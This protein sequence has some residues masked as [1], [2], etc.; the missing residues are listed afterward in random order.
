MDRVPENGLVF[1][2]PNQGDELVMRLMSVRN[3]PRAC[4]LHAMGSLIGDYM[5]PAIGYTSPFMM[6]LG[7]TTQD[8][9]ET[10]AATQM[11]SAR[12]T[13]KADSPMAKYMPEMRD[14]KADWDIACLLYTSRCV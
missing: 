8:F 9:E 7:I 1:G 11:K 5:Q 10:R 14:I 12:A 6:T 4:T 13:Q 2:T 3:Y